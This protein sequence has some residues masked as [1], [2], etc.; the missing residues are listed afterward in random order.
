M[1]EVR[2]RPTLERKLHCM[3]LGLAAFRVVASHRAA[4]ATSSR[5]SAWLQIEAVTAGVVWPSRLLTT[6]SGTP[7][8]SRRPGWV[9][10]VEWREMP[11]RRS[12]PR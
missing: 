2:L 6:G 1:R 9:H 7:R 3:A 12:L 5:E 10:R 11:V 8:L 4:A